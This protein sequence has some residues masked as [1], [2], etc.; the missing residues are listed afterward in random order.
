MEVDEGVVKERRVRLDESTADADDV[1]FRVR[2][3][4]G[5]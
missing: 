2:E 1:E 4:L 5:V 3:M